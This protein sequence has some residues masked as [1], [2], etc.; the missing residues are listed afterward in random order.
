M[1]LATL[2]R[3]HN[4]IEEIVIDIKQ[5]IANN[6]VDEDAAH[7][8]KQISMLTGKLRIHLATEDKHM[9]PYLLETGDARVKA[10]AKD[11]A[12][13]MG[14]ISQAFM[15]YKDKFN[16]KTKII[17]SPQDFVRETKEIFKVLQERMA[18][19]DTQLYKYI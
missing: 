1:D 11:Y 2:Q 16:T 12:D 19:E 17:N 6:N 7:M 4:E 10:L 13:E 9:Y 14:H 8:A 18:K 15:V 3:Q 5:T